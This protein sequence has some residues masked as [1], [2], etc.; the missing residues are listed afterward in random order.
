[1]EQGGANV[2][3]AQADVSSV[4][5]MVRVLEAVKASMPPLRGVVHAAGVTG[6]QAIKD[7]DFNTLEEVLR[8][9]V[10]GTWILHQLTQGIKL[11]FF[12]SF[13]SIASVWGS[14][15]Q[16][17]Y[18]AANH[19][20]DVLAHYRQG[21]GLPALSVNWG[22][23]ADGGMAL[24]EFQTWLTRMGVEVLPP[25]LALA[26]LGYLLGTDCVQTTV[27]NIDWT[28]FK[29]LYEARGKRSLLEQIEV[30][31]QK[32]A[33]QQEVQRSEILQ[34]LESAQE[35]DRHSLLMTYL[36]GEVAKV[37]RLSQLPDP[38]QG[39]F[40]MGMDSL[41]AIELVNLIRS[42]FQ[43]ELQRFLFG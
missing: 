14:K 2:L 33:Q 43:V 15:G 29:G 23:W 38:Q 20:L 30:H 26:A 32:A 25:K 6:Y 22:P 8:P 41:I 17:H 39:L 10:V 40:D 35:R 7:M 21:F 9:K 16:A 36:Q 12:V 34:R 18:A 13:S 11:D 3:V 4:G 19:F 1:M 27:A 37:L 42:Q 28:L 24:A 31:S 5:D